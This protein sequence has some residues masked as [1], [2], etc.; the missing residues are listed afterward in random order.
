MRFLYNTGT[1]HKIPEAS[2]LLR[3]MISRVMH[4]NKNIIMGIV[5]ETG[6]GKSWT[7]LS[8]MQTIYALLDREFHVQKCMTWTPYQFMTQHNAGYP[9]GSC[10]CLDEGGTAINAKKFMSNVNIAIGNL[11]QTSRRYNYIYLIN[12]PDIT[13]LDKTTRKLLHVIIETRKID[14]KNNRSYVVPKLVQCNRS[15]IDNKSDSKIMYRFLRIQLPHEPMRPLKGVWVYKPTDSVIEEYEV[16]KKDFTDRLNVQVQSIVKDPSIDVDGKSDK[17]P[18]T[19]LEARFL[20]LRNLEGVSVTGAA[21]VLDVSP[22]RAGDML[23]K[24]R[25]KGYGVS[26]KKGKAVRVGDVEN[27]RLIVDKVDKDFF[28][29]EKN[30]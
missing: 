10:I 7:A 13:F 12:L 15:D 25:L 24:L 6:S 11:F 8:I 21:S 3:W 27:Y 9:K 30:V 4:Q 5:G 29:D 18:L 17:S 14:H 22:G 1:Q 20:Y 26:M 23:A 16:L 2:I 28:E 19:D